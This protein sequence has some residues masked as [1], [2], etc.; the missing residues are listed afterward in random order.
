MAGSQTALCLVCYKPMSV[1][2]SDDVPEEALREFA[3]DLRLNANPVENTGWIWC[4]DSR[5]YSHLPTIERL[6]EEYREIARR[7]NRHIKK[8]TASGSRT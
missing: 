5:C 3:C 8:Q 2:D 4:A 7:L 1:I 6:L